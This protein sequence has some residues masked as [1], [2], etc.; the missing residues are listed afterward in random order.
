MEILVKDT[1]TKSF[2]FRTINARKTRRFI[3]FTFEGTKFKIRTLVP[4]Y[5]SYAHTLYVNLRTRS[6]YKKLRKLKKMRITSS[7]S[8]DSIIAS[9]YTISQQGKKFK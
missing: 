2:F 6:D 8:Y 7:K 5:S 3:S 9:Y 1:G 4:W